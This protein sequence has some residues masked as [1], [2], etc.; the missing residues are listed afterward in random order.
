MVVRGPLV[1]IEP[2]VAVVAMIHSAVAGDGS[3]CPPKPA[4]TVN[5]WSPSLSVPVWK[6]LV[7]GDGSAS[8]RE[9][10]NVAPAWSEWNVMVLSAVCTIPTG[11]LSMNVSGAGD[12]AP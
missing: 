7:Q 2:L 9:H 6:G 10:W 4:A 3:V 8:S 5:V 1:K 12:A 11:A